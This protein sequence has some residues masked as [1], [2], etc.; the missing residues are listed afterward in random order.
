M[1]AIR[2]I[3]IIEAIE[4]NRQFDSQ[5]RKNG[6]QIVIALIGGIEGAVEHQ[7]G[8]DGCIIDVDRRNGGISQCN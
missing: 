5:I 8:C 6:W 2:L 1:S 3:K 4:R 7:G